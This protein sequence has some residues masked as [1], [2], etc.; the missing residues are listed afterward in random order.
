MHQ[1]KKVGRNAFAANL[2]P[3]TDRQLETADVFLAGPEHLGGGTDKNTAI[4]KPDERIV[5]AAAEVFG[6]G[7]KDISSF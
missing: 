4:L 3:A 6:P 2:F 7:E 1:T 5:G